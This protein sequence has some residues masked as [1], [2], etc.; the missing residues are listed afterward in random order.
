M[1]P[2]AGI[3]SFVDRL[4][5]NLEHTSLDFRIYSSCITLNRSRHCQYLIHEKET[6]TDDKRLQK[7]NG[8]NNCFRLKQLCLLHLT[9][10]RSYP[11]FDCLFHL[12]RSRVW[13]LDLGTWHGQINYERLECRNI[14]HKLTPNNGPRS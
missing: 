9:S 10:H 7:I 6:S 5:S 11:I 1:R 2:M 13:K 4:A 8:K 12:F 14:C 3:A